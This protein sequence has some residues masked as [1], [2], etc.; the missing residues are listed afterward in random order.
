MASNLSCACLLILCISVHVV[1]WRNFGLKLIA[2][3]IKEMKMLTSFASHSRVENVK[4]CW[5]DNVVLN[6]ISQQ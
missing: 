5:V 4:C 2:S 3:E 1:F 6:E